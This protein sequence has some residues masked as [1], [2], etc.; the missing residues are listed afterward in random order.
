MDRTDATFDIEVVTRRLVSMDVAVASHDELVWADRAAHR[1]QEWYAAMQAAVRVE[2][3]L[4]RP[5]PPLDAD[6]TSAPDSAHDDAA[7]AAS[8]PDGG[9][10]AAPSGMPGDGPGGAAAGE[11]PPLGDAG[12]FETAA[13]AAR[14]DRRADALAHAP[15]FAAAYRAGRIGTAHVDALANALAAVTDD[16]RDRVLLQVD[17][18]LLDAERCGPDQFQRSIRRRVDRALADLGVD[19]RRRQRAQSSL[20][21]GVDPAT[22]M[23]W[24][25]LDVDPERGQQLFDAIDAEKEAIW[26]GGHASGLTPQQVQLQALLNLIGR[27]GDERK[28]STK[29]IN[30]LI[31]VDIATLLDGPHD[32]SICETGSGAPLDA[33]TMRRLMCLASVR[34]GFTDRGRIVGMTAVSDLATPDQ[35]I[36]LRGMYP[37]CAFPGC[38]VPFDSTQIHHILHRAKGGPTAVPYMIPLCTKTHHGAVHDDGW[39]VAIDAQRTLTWHTPAGELYAVAPFDDPADRGATHRPAVVRATQRQ[40]PTLTAQAAEAAATLV[41]AT[42]E[43]P[44]DVHADEAITSSR[45]RPEPPTGSLAPAEHERTRTTAPVRAGPAQP[46][47]FGPDD[48][49]AP[50]SNDPTAA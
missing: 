48:G 13:E 39:T 49:A 30:G 25:R 19:R 31:L 3:A 14:R 6:D 43:P 28:S 22:Q 45:R 42:V 16:V 20:H 4:P 47:L 46:A 11:L 33:D 10:A 17:E 27:P 32:R 5:L 38:D 1:G 44:H 7:D 36:A 37:T 41:P 34:F 9:A 18:L 2:L 8:T 40:H 24:L 35:R 50:S 26:H 15:A 21:K 29:R 12:R 23:H